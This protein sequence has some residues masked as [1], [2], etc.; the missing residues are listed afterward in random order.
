MSFVTTLSPAQTLQTAI[1]VPA[2][3][4]PTPAFSLTLTTNISSTLGGPPGPPSTVP[5]P[6]GPQGIPGAASTVPGPT[7]PA[8][9][10]STVPGPAGPQGVPGASGSGVGGIATVT[11][12]E[13]RGVFEHAQTVAAIGV[14]LAS[15]VTISLAQ[16][17]TDVAE[18]DPEM[19]DVSS[20]WA[21]PGVDQINVG[22][23]FG[24]PTSGPI[25]INWSAT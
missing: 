11:I 3:G 23:T 1:T 14:S 8:G 22:I 15:R 6:A 20:M 21:T 7:G 17:A 13:V 16:D 19:L 5:G 25:V 10:A 12:A 18:N 9:A 24:T 2:T 4:M